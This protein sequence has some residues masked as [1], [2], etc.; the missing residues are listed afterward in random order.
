MTNNLAALTLGVPAYFHPAEYPFEWQ[1][2]QAAP[3]RMRFVVL[4][5]NSGP[6]LRRDPY[7]APVAQALLAAGV[8]AIGYVATDYGQRSPGEVAYEVDCY[9][10]W[11]GIEGVF[12]D[13]VSAGL[14]QLD[15]YA[16]TVLAART[17]GARFVVLHPGT[18]PHPGYI[19]LANVTVT[20][21][22]TWSQYVTLQ[23]PS[24]VTRFP[25]TRFCHLIHTVPGRE[26]RPGLQLALDRHARTVCLTEGSGDNPWG[27]LPEAVIN[28][29]LES[30]TTR[31][32]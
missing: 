16:Q 1:T 23:Q 28:E 31:A 17:A 4:N 19:D 5:V 18:H 30:R 20:F 9:R 26:L 32:R 10:R 14:D 29:L 2:L 27:Q 22:G 25:A 21:E 13:Q 6:G 8:R 12:M 24:W 3:D 7:Y 15:H 11:Y